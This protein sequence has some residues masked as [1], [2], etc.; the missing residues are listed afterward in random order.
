M[1]PAN[2]ITSKK[3]MEACAHSR[4]LLPLDPHTHRHTHT[5]RYILVHQHVLWPYTLYL[6][7]YI[8]TFF[9]PH[10]T[11]HIL[12]NSFTHDIILIIF[13]QIYFRVNALC[14]SSYILIIYTV[15]VMKY[16]L[17][18]SCP[19]FLNVIVTRH[20]KGPYTHC[21]LFYNIYKIESMLVHISCFHKSEWGY[22]VG[23]ATISDFL[24]THLG[25]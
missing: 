7:I 19:G 8:Y 4:R 24:H 6:C 2:S 10:L 23:H 16:H 15:H 5:Q 22:P 3:G 17:L 18:L 21:F 9:I 25:I 1:Q 12:L 20:T 11:P 13:H 14:F